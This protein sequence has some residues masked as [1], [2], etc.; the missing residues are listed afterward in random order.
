[1]ALLNTRPRIVLEHLDRTYGVRILTLM[2]NAIETALQAIKAAETR[3]RSARTMNRLW[4]AYF[5]AVDA[6][7]A[8]GAWL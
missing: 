2:N 1:M 3:N 8:A 6:A 7:K 4:K 5:A